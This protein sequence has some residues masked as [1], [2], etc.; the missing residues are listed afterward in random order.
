MK[1]FFNG[2]ETDLEYKIED[3]EVAPSSHGWAKVTLKLTDVHGVYPEKSVTMTIAEMDIDFIQHHLMM[4]RNARDA[5]RRE[6]TARGHCGTCGVALGQ[7]DDGPDC[8]VCVE[9]WIQNPPPA[10]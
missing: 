9:W 3:I 7:D 6:P 2:A 10:N 4:Y 1:F 5:S 8:P